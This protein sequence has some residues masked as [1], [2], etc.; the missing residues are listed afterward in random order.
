MLNEELRTNSGLTYG[1]GA[2]VE[3]DRLPGSIAISS[4]TKTETTV[5]AVDLA[6]TILKK[7]ASGGISAEQLQSA[8]AYVKGQFP[9]DVLET[10]DQ[11]ADVVGEMELYELP[12]DEIDGYFA[13]I[14]AVTPA[15]ATA[16]ARKYYRSD[17]LLMVMVGPAGKIL[18][19]VKK[20][21]ASVVPVSAKTPG[22]G[23]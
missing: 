4:Y 7:L 10:A 6:L 13:R 16:V 12:R 15:Q 2:R 9:T 5:Q 17:E 18:D 22:W 3:E 19:S 20:Y 11:L 21:D 1:A 14:D 23:K 8:K